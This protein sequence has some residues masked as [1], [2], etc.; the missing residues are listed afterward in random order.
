MKNSN[1]ITNW[2]KTQTFTVKEV[3][4]LNPH[5]EKEITCRVN[6]NA[7][8]SDQKI[9]EFGAKTGGKGRPE[10]LYAYL[11]ITSIMIQKAK[12]QKVNLADGLETKYLNIV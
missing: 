3:W 7:Q 2:P 5:I 9:I 12:T 11:P 8:K 1:K 10:K 4:K 6:F